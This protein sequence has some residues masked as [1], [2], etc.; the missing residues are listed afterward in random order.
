MTYN[1]SAGTL[2]H[3]IPYYFSV[4]VCCVYFLAISYQVWAWMLLLK[5][6]W[7]FVSSIV[8]FNAAWNVLLSSWDW[9]FNVSI[10]CQKTVCAEYFYALCYL[11]AMSDSRWVHPVHLMNVEW[12]QVATD[13]RPNQYDL[14]CGCQSL[15]LPLPFI[16]ITQPKSWYS[17]YRPM[18]GRVDLGGWLHTDMVYPL[19]GG[20]PSWY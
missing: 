16:I 18:E 12:R 15:H 17:F 11:A 3:T 1:I 4:R 20:R 13:P 19:T 8:W 9:G 6:F 14:G 7:G 2:D 5:H 10:C